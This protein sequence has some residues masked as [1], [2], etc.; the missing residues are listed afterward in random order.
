MYIVTSWEDDVRIGAISVCYCIL[1]F[2][3]AKFIYVDCESRECDFLSCD[4]CIYRG[5]RIPGSRE[6]V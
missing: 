6:L 2:K 1:I 3:V 5:G 4:Y